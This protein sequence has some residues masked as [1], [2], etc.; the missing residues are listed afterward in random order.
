MTFKGFLSKV[1]DLLLEVDDLITE[2]EEKKSEIEEKAYDR[3][4]GENT[5]K[6]LEKIEK[7]ETQIT[8]LEDF[9]DNIDT[10]EVDE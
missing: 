2:L 10:S 7:L 5:E 6:E 3:A 9:R 1:T 4:S 8:F